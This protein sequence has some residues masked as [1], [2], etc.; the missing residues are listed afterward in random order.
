MPKRKG[1]YTPEERAARSERQKH[2]FKSLP[3]SPTG[4]ILPKDTLP[5]LPAAAAVS[6]GL[7]NSEARSRRRLTLATLD[8]MQ[9]AFDRGGQK[10]IE[11]VMKTQ[12]GIFLKML[13]LLVPREMNIEHSGSVKEMTDQQIEDAIAAIKQMMADRMI[14]VTPTTSSV[15][16]PVSEADDAK[17]LK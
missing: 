13:V 2:R 14:D 9:R 6:P 10:A 7:P 8:G 12:P 3:L 15:E 17:P 11:K 5:A 4:Q 1:T 16:T